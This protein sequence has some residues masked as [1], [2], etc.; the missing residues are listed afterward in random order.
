MGTTRQ[1]THAAM[2]MKLLT[3]RCAAAGPTR[4]QRSIRHLHQRPHLICA[5]LVA[6]MRTCWPVNTVL[7]GFGSAASLLH[8]PSCR[9]GDVGVYSILKRHKPTKVGLERRQAC[10]HDTGDVFRALGHDSCHCRRTPPRWCCKITDTVRVLKMRDT[11]QNG[12]AQLGQFRLI[13]HVADGIITA[14][15]VLGGRCPGATPGRY[16]VGNAAE[17]FCD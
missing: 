16:R 4:R 5:E 6:G 11:H 17:T 14:S 15:P 2:G 8:V 13:R 9:P 10:H 1:P 7:G 3:M 12:A